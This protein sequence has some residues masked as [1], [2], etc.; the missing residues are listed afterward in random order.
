[1]TKTSLLSLTLLA[2]VA[3]AA[4]SAQAADTGVQTEEGLNAA[5]VTLSLPSCANKG[6]IVSVGVSFPTVN[7][8]DVTVALFQPTSGAP[9]M[10]EEKISKR[11]YA[12]PASGTSHTFNIDSF[13]QIGGTA[14]VKVS[15]A[16]AGKASGSFQIPCP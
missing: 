13:V 7:P 11:Q 10:L 14:K 5:G 9:Y 16:G 2:L 15:V 6:D 1:M 12:G 4:T 8:V 3:G